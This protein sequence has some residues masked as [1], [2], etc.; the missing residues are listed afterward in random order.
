MCVT[1]TGSKRVR[2]KYAR[3]VLIASLVLQLFQ[4]G[5]EFYLDFLPQPRT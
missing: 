5:A 4:E 2:M 3:D 1:K